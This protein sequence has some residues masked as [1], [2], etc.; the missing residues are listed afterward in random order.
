MSGDDPHSPY[1]SHWRATY[2]THDGYKIDIEESTLGDCYAQWDWT[3]EGDDW[4]VDYLPDIDDNEDVALWGMRGCAVGITDSGDYMVAGTARLD[5]SGAELGKHIEENYQLFLLVFDD[6]LID[7]VY[8]TSPPSHG[9]TSENWW[10]FGTS[11]HD[12]GVSIR[13]WASGTCLPSNALV[14]VGTQRR[15]MFPGTWR[16]FVGYMPYGSS[17]DSEELSGRNVLLESG[18]YEEL[19]VSY[20]PVDK[21]LQISIPDSRV[22]S[23]SLELYDI[24]GRLTG[25]T[26]A[27]FNG[28]NSID[29]PLASV[30]AGELPNGVYL[31]VIRSGQ[32]TKVCNCVVIR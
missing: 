9:I 10:L 29:V 14:V 8:N 31:A 28:N 4:E 18:I 24:S 16:I 17:N 25:R 19:W 13:K 5:M 6:A 2:S 7:G 26:I 32:D 3:E 27:D 12:E 20:S 22:G 1:L 23:A 11:G 15:N 30:Y 21:T